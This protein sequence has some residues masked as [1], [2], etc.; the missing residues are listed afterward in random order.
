[1]EAQTIVWYRFSVAALI[2][3]TGLALRKKLRPARPQTKT[4]FWLF[5]IAILGFASNNVIF[6]T[7]LGYVTPT[8]GQVVIQL[9]PMMLLLGGVFVF[10]ERF[11]RFQF[12]GLC[13][14]LGGMLTFF[15]E[16]LGELF[17]NFTGYAFGVFL[18]VVSAV[19]WALYALAQKQLLASY[20]S[21]VLMWIIY[22]AGAVLLFPLAEPAQIFRL[23]T[24]QWIVLF[25]C[26][27]LTVLGYG[28]FAEAL[29]HW[30]ATRVSAVVAI[31]PLI[32]WTLN[33][34]A[35]IWM[36][37]YVKTEDLSPISLVGAGIVT[38]GCAITALSRSKLT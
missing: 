16:R 7:G 24:T 31:T 14:L 2:L 34:I 27:M 9:A 4:I 25:Y 33:R 29:A 3:G 36:P 10:K 38:I 5:V 28:A 35:A 18:V 26:S 6:V 37:Q 12:V 13:L 15:H 20:G 21:P 32:T 23:D 19:A 30:E 8:V 17:G 1:M 22:S 11:G